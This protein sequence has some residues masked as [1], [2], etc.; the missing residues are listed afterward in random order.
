MILY[1]TACFD[2]TTDPAEDVKSA[3]SSALRDF[4][5]ENLVH[6]NGPG[7]SALRQ[8]REMRAEPKELRMTVEQRFNVQKERLR[9]QGE[10]IVAMTVS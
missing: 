3:V 7:L 6:R 4:I 8:L 1:E 2:K 9:V 5:D 10:R